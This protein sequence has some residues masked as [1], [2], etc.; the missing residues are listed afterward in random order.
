MKETLEREVVNVKEESSKHHT[1]LASAREIQI[2]MNEELRS[3]E[4]ERDELRDEIAA[5]QYELE[6]ARQSFKTAVEN[7]KIEKHKMEVTKRQQM[8]VIDLLQQ[9]LDAPKKKKKRTEIFSRE[10]QLQKTLRIA[11][12]ENARL[13]RDKVELEQKI[14]NLQRSISQDGSHIRIIEQ[15]TCKT[16]KATK[17]KQAIE[18]PGAPRP[19][20][21]GR[22][23]RFVT[24]LNSR[25][26]KCVLCLGNVEFVREATKCEECLSVCHS[27]CA[28]K[29]PP[30][31]GLKTEYKRVFDELFNEVAQNKVRDVTRL[32]KVKSGWI[33]IYRHRKN[34]WEKKWMV[35]KDNIL[36]IYNSDSVVEPYCE[37]IPL[38]DGK[39]LMR[40]AVNP[41]ELPNV[42]LTDL[43]LVF[44]IRR[45]K[46]MY[47]N[48][49]SVADKHH[50]VA[51]LDAIMLDDKSDKNMFSSLIIPQHPNYVHEACCINGCVCL[52]ATDEG[53]HFQSE[54]VKCTLSSFGQ[55][56]AIRYISQ[57]NT[58]VLVVFSSRTVAFA[59]YSDLL[60]DT[61]N[62]NF[63]N[64]LPLTVL[65]NASNC[66]TIEVGMYHRNVFLGVSTSEE[67]KLFVWSP[68]NDGFSLMKTLLIPK[69]ASCLMFSNDRLI[70]GSDRFYSLDFQNYKFKEFLNDKDPSLAFAIFGAAKFLSFPLNVF[71]INE[72][73]I[74]LCFTDFGIFVDSFGRRTREE[75]LNWPGEQPLMI[76]YS[77]PCLFLILSGSIEALLIPE[78]GFPYIKN[79]KIQI[80]SPVYVGKGVGRGTIL[81]T[82]EKNGHCDL[83][84]VIADLEEN[85]IE[86]IESE[87]DDFDDRECKKFVWGDITYS[88]KKE[89]MQKSFRNSGKKMKGQ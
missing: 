84:Q 82:A 49:G 2:K 42:C 73:E 88:P 24:G 50:W 81:V 52:L 20:V 70:V 87:I 11:L 25:P 35:L 6:K 43:P 80:P 71:Q 78:R 16:P 22:P 48:P 38:K 40:A 47:I 45:S 72:D 32:K 53:L 4:L 86:I 31:C 18:T 15:T 63:N 74:L 3:L 57:L 23:H 65:D 10:E 1:Q 66:T 83:L 68:K 30:N 79:E 39:T 37:D 55:V 62:K 41:V 27:F 13:S 69:P 28:P 7:E 51:Y 59:S 21:V 19:H 9:Q 85:H 54:E 5:Y 29:M 36:F 64:N 12:D 8:N 26:D 77:A 17:Q 33:T 56:N 61:T 89:I 67:L 60:G 34:I 44:S 58:I 76:A 14:R 75:D 46:T